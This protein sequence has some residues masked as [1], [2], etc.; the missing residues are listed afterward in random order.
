M[1]IHAQDVFERFSDHSKIGLRN[2]ASSQIIFNAEFNEIGW[3]NGS[4]EIN[5][6]KIGLKQN[7][8]WALASTNGTRITRH[9]YSSLYP[10]VDE[11]YIIGIRSNFSILND[12]G[13]IDSRGKEV[14]PTAYQ[15]IEPVGETLIVA[16]KIGKEYTYG[17]LNK[18]GKVLLPLE[19]TA[20]TK[21]DNNTLSVSNT[22]NL[23]ALVST[24]GVMMSDF[25][26]ETLLRYDENTFKI[27]FKNKEGLIDKAGNEI[28]PPKYKAFEYKNNNP[29]VLPFSDWTI[30]KET[31]N[32]HIINH[33]NVWILGP[34]IAVQTDD[35]AGIIDSN[36]SYAFGQPLATF[37]HSSSE[38][39]ALNFSGRYGVLNYEGIQVLPNMYDS[40]QFYPKALFA[41]T[42]S[43]SKT[44]WQAFSP[45]GQSISQYS[46]ETVLP[47]G[48]LIIAQK[49]G[50][51]G[52]LSSEGFEQSPFIFDSIG[53]FNNELAVAKYQNQ[54]GVIKPNGNWLITP[55]KDKI[56]IVSNRI[57]YQQGTESGVL[58]LSDFLIRRHSNP[59]IVFSNCYAEKLEEGMLLYDFNGVKLIGNPRDSIY[60]I[61]EKFIVLKTKEKFELL[62]LE[63]K[64]I[65]LLTKGIQEVSNWKEGLIAIKKDNEWGFISERG[66]LTIANRYQKA[67][68]FSEGLSAVQLNGMWGFINQ[69]EAIVIQPNYEF[70]SSFKEGLAIVKQNGLYGLINPQGVLILDL[71]YDEINAHPNFFLLKK[72]TLVGLADKKGRLIRRPQFTQVESQDDFYFIASKGNKQGVFSIKGLDIL[73][74]VYDLIKQFGSSFAAKEAQGWEALRKN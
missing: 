2:T 59:L 31:G 4:F 20:I 22:E 47:F 15:W 69:S 6:E 54:L 43:S 23:A 55:Y 39:I 35:Y 26:Y 34:T 48:D 66:K 74:I 16:K 18:N 53:D 51:Y 45:S 14:I 27:R 52:L 44:E 60:E 72:D 65:V 7:E 24:K 28:I 5:E 41:A 58:N 9:Y 33:D 56:K 50:K 73:P 21:L 8:K 17:L 37:T 64:A 19:Y 40:I 61:S 38:L 36:R 62:N 10:F 29:Q 57:F 12:Y 11:K 71:D 13:L 32:S 30:T 25:I 67:K 63:N 42:N 1:D 68:D 46:Y 70:A 49:N 3:S